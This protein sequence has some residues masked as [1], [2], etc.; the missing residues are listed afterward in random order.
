M[1]NRQVDLRSLRAQGRLRDIAK[2]RPPASILADGA[3]S[4]FEISVMRDRLP[5]EH[6]GRLGSVNRCEGP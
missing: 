2:N 1:R 6:F 4:V 3:P 5:S